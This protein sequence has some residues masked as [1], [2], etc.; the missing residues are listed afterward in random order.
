MQID[1]IRTEQ[2][3][4]IVSHAH[5]IVATHLR[6]FACLCV[7]VLS[8]CASEPP[9]VPPA[10]L[11][12]TSSEVSP[13]RLWSSKSGKSG[14]G[15]FEPLVNET[16]VVVANAEGT[17]TSYST[18][19]G[20]RRWRA[21]LNVRLTSG[22]GG[23]SERVYVSDVN[24]VVH[25]LDA[26]TGE[27]LW[28]TEASSEIL[29]PVAAGFDSALVRSTDGRLVALEETNGQERWSL[30]NTP[31]ALTLNGYSRPRLLE[32]GVLLGLDDGR[33][34]A[35]NLA[36]GRI[37]WE[38]VISVPSG[39]SE[40]ERLVDIDADIVVDDE[41]IY[42]ANYQ[43][44]AARLEP[45]R[46]QLVWSVPMSAG[47]GLAIND[48]SLIVVDDN[49]TVYRLEKSSGQIIWTNET[50][51]GRRLSPPAFAST[52]DIVL[53]DVEGYIHVLDLATG[54]SIGRTRL[55]DEPIEAR[56]A[57]IDNALVIQA[58]DGLVAAYRF[59]R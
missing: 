33:V 45:A 40:I 59:A 53:G 44:K 25:A 4:S 56:A 38:T 41:G 14:R 20:I 50:M 48:D 42:L 18:D 1:E 27:A 39:R 3:K 36:N 57:S 30:S 12:P 13:L 35:L 8:G 31:P 17:V 47:S 34:L 43:G 54:E 21:S 58:V 15:L 16:Q 19:N 52:G 2:V 24:G 22:V 32:G 26:S 51:P 10:E 46:G 9:P 49:D 5:S 29:V 37:I 55:T 6:V 23:N 7:I 28:Q 11:K